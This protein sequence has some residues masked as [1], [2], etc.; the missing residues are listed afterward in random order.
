MNYHLQCIL[1]VVSM[2]G[3]GALLYLIYPKLESNWKNVQ[4]FNRMVYYTITG[5][6]Y[7]K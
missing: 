7:H 3:L 2:F 1:P 5:K 4:K 6:H